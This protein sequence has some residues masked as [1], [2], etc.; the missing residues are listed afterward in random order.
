MKYRKFGNTGIE[1]SR[2]GFGCMR[3]PTIKLNDVEVVDEDKTIK[4]IHR[5]YELGVN[6]YDTAYFYHDGQSEIVLG[7][8]LKGIRDKVYVS[9]KSPG[10]LIKK[11][12]DY[13]KIL[14]EQLK[15]LDI[16]YIDVYHFH[17]IG[18]DG[19]LSINEKTKWLDEAYKAKEEGLIKHIS[20]SFHDAPENLKRLVDLGIFE[21]VL[22]QYNAIDRS[23]EDAIAYAKSKGLGVVIMGPVGGGR[24]SGLPKE[25]A[26]K[27]GINVKSSAE[28][29]L[30]FVFSNPDVDCA[31]SGMG[32][33]EMVEENSVTA[34]NIEPLSENEV[35][36]INKMME[37]NRKLADL[38]CTGCSYCMPCP[39]GVNIP[40]IFEMMNYHKV[41]G[42]D[43][44]SKNGYAEIGTNEWVPGK[45]ADACVECG[46][47]ETKCPQKLKIREQLKECH[48][49]LA[50]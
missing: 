5:A 17:G 7:K 36:A 19:F 41:Y 31:L 4:M 11:H 9:T 27:L 1:I 28:M 48:K 8:A 34:S 30:R 10:H 24:V 45:R 12:G 32:S 21:S 15:K 23:N 49:V 33:M 3:L 39:A 47:C 18:Y 16:D 37:E 50:R 44:Y 46:V 43:E 26:A 6:Y 20:F 40:K 25:V 42:I 38:Y 35:I 29:A 13:R 14:E 2:L 22:C